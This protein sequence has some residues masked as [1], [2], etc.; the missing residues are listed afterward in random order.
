MLALL[1]QAYDYSG[2]AA[3]GVA[4]AGLF[5]GLAIFWIIL[6]LI[7]AV[8]GLIFL[9]WWIVLII[10]LSKRDFPEK[11]TWMIIMI[12]GF[13]L[14]IW[15]VDLLYYFMIVKKHGKAGAGGGTQATPPA[16]TPPA[17]PEQK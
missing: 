13:F 17:A 10:D 8:A 16:S 14:A 15:L 1:A 7:F 2:D 5:G 11:N 9:I 12:V 6:W 3:A 4:A